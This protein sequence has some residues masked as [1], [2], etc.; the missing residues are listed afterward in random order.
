MGFPFF[1]KSP[2]PGGKI[3][4]AFASQ[5][6]A[7]ERIA[8]LSAN[9]LA[10][11]GFVRVAALGSLT[12]AEIAEAGTL[13][14]VTS[15]Y[16][17]GEAP[18]SARG[19]VRKQM[20]QPPAFK[21]LNFAVMALGDRKYDATFCGFGKGLDRWLAA[22]KAKRLFDLVCV[23]GDDDEAAMSR[24]CEQLNTLGAN[25]SAEAL[26]P[27]AP[28]DWTLA[29]RRLLNP[30]SP[31]GEAWHIALAPKDAAQLAWVAGDI[32]EIWPRNA[33]GAV[34]DFLV[35]HNLNGELSFRWLGNWVFL[36][37]IIAHSRLPRDHEVEGV[38]LDWLVQRLEPFP[39]RE[40]SIASLPQSG[41][42]ELLVR[43]AVKDD[44]ALGLGSG[45]LTQTAEVGGLVKL[46]L[47]PNP[48]FQPPSLKEKGEGPMILIGAGTGIAGL[49]AHLLH[50]Q[51]EKLGDAW[52]LF[53]ERGENTD[54][55]YADDIAA[56]RQDGT[57]AKTDLVFSRDAVPKKYVQHLVAEQGGNVHA[58]VERGAS[59][60][61]CGG[62]EMAAGVQEALTAILGEDRLEAMTQDGLYRRDIY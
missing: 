40:Y 46:R 44:G 49:R 34:D 7:A 21:G 53:G 18:D 12:L 31:G 14:V 56:W 29:E 11:A 35:R 20:A 47:R 23:D 15:T 57:L 17:A 60:M 27:G 8:W 61:V 62:L 33:Q 58:W 30:G 16:G 55:Y 37:D 36:R 4:V 50:R 13:L 48:N 5:T 19:F 42:M 3:L 38:S 22:G 1:R 39:P 52:L 59:I 6:G 54:L 2:R 9:A 32:A 45:W 51:R 28:K 25:T 43:K 24:W 26:M 10:G 41:R